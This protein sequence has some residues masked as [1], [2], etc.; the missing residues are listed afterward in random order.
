M[1]KYFWIILAIVL[2]AALFVGI[3]LTHRSD[4]SIDRASSPNGETEIIPD[5]PSEPWPDL[6]TDT[7]S[8]TSSDPGAASLPTSSGAPNNSSPISS[9]NTAAS[10]NAPVSSEGSSASGSTSS[11]HSASSDNPAASGGTVSSSGSST[12][13]TDPDSGSPSVPDSGPED[14]DLV[15]STEGLH[16]YELPYISLESNQ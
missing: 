9:G 15:V 6:S 12:S 11:S 8:N 7:S 3:A 16:E 13:D 4:A 1:K 2:V 14:S 10:S 5:D